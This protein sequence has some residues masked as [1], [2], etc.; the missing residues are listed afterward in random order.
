MESMKLSSDILAQC[1]AQSMTFTQLGMRIEALSLQ[2]PLFSSHTARFEDGGVY[3]GRSEEL[4]VPFGGERCLVIAVGGVMPKN[5][6][7]GKTCVFHIDDEVDLAVVFNILQE[8][9]AYYDRWSASLRA[10]LDGSAS[11]AEMI[12]V[13]APVLGNPITLLNNRL[14]IEASCNPGDSPYLALLAAEGQMPDRFKGQFLDKQ[15]YRGRYW[16]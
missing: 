16:G 13:T 10:I 8:T 6:V 12:Q 3:L 14:E 5:R 15:F 9:F 11:I 2:P 7:L 1:L 4:A